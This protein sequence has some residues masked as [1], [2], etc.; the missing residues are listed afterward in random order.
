MKDDWSLKEKH[1][2][3]YVNECYGYSDSDID[4]LR[5]KLIKDIKE[6]WAYTGQKHNEGDVIII[7]NKRFGFEMVKVNNDM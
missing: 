4:I 3:N 7:I 6:E 2:L 1:R 5:Q